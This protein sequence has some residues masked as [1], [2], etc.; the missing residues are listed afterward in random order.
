MW[1]SI[2]IRFGWLAAIGA[3]SQ[4]G[5]AAEGIPQPDPGG[6]DQD[7]DPDGNDPAEGHPATAHHAIIAADSAAV[8]HTVAIV[9][10]IATAIQEY[11]RNIE[12][13]NHEQDNAYD[14]KKLVF[15]HQIF[16]FLFSLSE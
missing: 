10:P 7:H 5:S 15:L 4:L 6:D 14:P 13:D 3:G 8:H 16:P 12:Q 2:P 9:H 1:T 11:A